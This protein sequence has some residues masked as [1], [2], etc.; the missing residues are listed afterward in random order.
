MNDEWRR[1]LDQQK[2]LRRILNPLGEAFRATDTLADTY[3][4]MELAKGALSHFQQEEARRKLLSGLAGAGI[5]ATTLADLERQHRLF[6]GPMKEAQRLGLFDRDSD[7]AGSMTAVLTARQEYERL[8]RLPE[9]DQIGRFARDALMIGGTI[10]RAS[11]Q[12]QSTV[13]EAMEA[14]HTPWLRIEQD[15]ASAKA[16]AEIIGIGGGLRNIPSFDPD[17]A[18]ALRS[19]LGDWRDPVS[20]DPLPLIDPM[21]RTS[22]YAERG[23]NFDLTDFTPAAFN[24]GL[25]L[26]GLREDEAASEDGEHE[27]GFARAK[28]A[29][30]RLHRLEVAL[31]RFIDSALSEVFGPDWMKTQLPKDMLEGWMDKREKAIR[32]GQPEY[33][34][35]DYADFTDYKPIIERKDNWNRVF[36]RVFGRPEDIR[37]SFQRL[38]PVRIATMHARII[39]QEDELLLLVEVGRV[40]KAIGQR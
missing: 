38:F 12:S 14:M 17:F 6:E 37:E 4:K 20:L 15:R 2:E 34:L 3:K 11:A 24:E 22:L 31:R 19:G 39:T 18:S 30:D 27:E 33:P 32:A 35:I 28:E 9:R 8:F 13:Q 7:L 1:M 10:S 21:I 40:I 25:D 36:R 5:A 26:A 16:F 23:F 29:Y